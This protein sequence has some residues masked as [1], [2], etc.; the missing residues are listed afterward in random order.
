MTE[1]GE[2]IGLAAANVLYVDGKFDAAKAVLLKLKES[3]PDDTRVLA[4]LGNIALFENYPGEAEGYFTEALNRAS[5]FKRMWP[6]NL[7]LK[8]RLA[9]TY[10]RMDRLREASRLFREAAG[11]LRFGPLKDLHAL[12]AQ[13]ALFDDASAYRIEGPGASHIGFVVTDPLPVV[14]LSVNGSEPLLFF[15]DTGGAE[16][17]LDSE[18]VD[19]VGA[20]IVSEMTGEFAGSKAAKVG[21]GKVDV[22]TLGDYSIANVPVSRLAVAGPVSEIFGRPDIQGVIG[23]RLLFHFRSTID[24]ANGRLILERKTADRSPSM[25][26]AATQPIVIPFWLVD[27]HYMM[28]WGSVNGMPPSL[29]FVD[30]GLAAKGFTASEAVLNWAGIDVDWSKS[31]ESTGGGGKVEMV[32]IT[33]QQLTL[34]SEPNQ[35]VET[36]VPGAAI[37]DDNMILKGAL[38]FQVGGL[39]SHQFFRRYAV[40]LD[41]S[42]MEI[43]LQQPGRSAQQGATE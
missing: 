28:A 29:F 22:V 32:D 25:E 13:L 34:G 3:R 1:S 35:A 27:T 12:S 16:L 17:I 10:Y 41:F 19:G 33:V 18:L 2:K 20:T 36:D 26:A 8:V 37:Q 5:R 7:A 31:V 23:T 4:Q 21:L 39:I 14:Q 6:F 40:T 15:L 24:Y 43:I 42:T 38:G 30:T 11:P 9:M